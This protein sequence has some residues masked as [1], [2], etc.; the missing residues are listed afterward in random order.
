MC[1]TPQVASLEAHDTAVK[2]G[3]MSQILLWTSIFEAF[4]TVAVVQMIN[5]S[6]RQPGYF[7]FD[8]LNFSK[9]PA[10][11]AKLELNEVK[12]GRLAMLAFSGIVTQAALGHAMPYI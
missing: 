4:S 12:N 8:P 3:A 2:F 10:S 1:A 6:G 9:D 5:G 11:K 7:G